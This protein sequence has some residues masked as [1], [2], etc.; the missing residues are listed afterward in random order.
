V[1]VSAAYEMAS[2]SLID[3]FGKEIKRIPV[4]GLMQLRVENLE[5]LPPG[6]YVLRVTYE[7]GSKSNHKIVHLR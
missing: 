3:M 7:N 1:N 6:T 5:N 4:N 2:I